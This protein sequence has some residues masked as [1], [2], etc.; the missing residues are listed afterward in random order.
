MRVLS[1][2]CL[3]TE[4]LATQVC[5]KQV[6]LNTPVDISLPLGNNVGEQ[7]GIAMFSQLV[8]HWHAESISTNG[9]NKLKY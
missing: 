1:I 9:Q 2:S 7:T 5:I 3:P 8:N 4:M 6:Y